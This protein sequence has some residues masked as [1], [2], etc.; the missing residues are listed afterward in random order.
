MELPVSIARTES[1]NRYMP[2][3][4]WHVSGRTISLPTD[5]AKAHVVI[6]YM[7]AETIPAFVPAHT[8]ISDNKPDFKSAALLETM[9]CLKKLS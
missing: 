5:H 7:G 6:N 8:I 4:A 1:G 9:V 2:I 3:A